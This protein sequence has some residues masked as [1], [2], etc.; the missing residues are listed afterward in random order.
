MHIIVS[1]LTYHYTN[2]QSLFEAIRFSVPPGGKAAIVGS[3]G[4][5][6][7]TLLKLLAGRLAPVSGSIACA[8]HPYYI[9]QQPDLAGTSVAEALGAAGK[10]AALHAIC[11]GSTDP[12]HYDA[13]GDDWEIE[14][15][16]RAALDG[17]GLRHVAPDAPA[18]AL[19]GGEKTK[20]LL[21][22]AT[23]RQPEILLL[24]EPTNHL[25]EAGRRQLYAFV[26]DT[27]ATVVVV[28]HDITLLNLLETIYELS[29]LGLKRYGGNYD[30]Y[31]QQKQIE[32]QAIE[33]HLDAA[34][35]A[36][37]QAR[38]R[39]QEVRERQEKRAAQGE[40]KKDQSPRILRK[41]LKDSGERTASRL[42]DQHAALIGRDSEKIAELRARQQRE[43]LLR[44][45]FD[46]AQLHNGKLLA[47]A[48]GVNFAYPGGAPL[49]SAPL[50]TTIRSG[51]RIRLRGGNGTGK[52][53]LVKLLTGEL[54]PTKGEIRRSEFSRVCLDQEYSRL[55]T[56]ATV[57]ETAQACNRSHLE[58]HELK[59]RLHRAL[60]P[61]AA[62]DKAC[63]TLSGGE[64]MRLSLCCL[65][66]ENQ[67][68]D[69]FILDEPTNNL[70]LQS[71]GILTD[72]IRNYRGTLLLIS[73][74]SRFAEEVGIT[75]TIS[76]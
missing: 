75:R 22:G 19:S 31:R 29:P 21:A 65:I 70:D 76:L 58:E 40:K 28:S 55:D 54:E 68:P 53:T 12:A 59:T 6:K 44:I 62:W 4:T 52:T 38:R 16:C 46:D 47:E 49:W 67:V 10:L 5:G 26:R 27:R 17:W 30:F 64:R 24:D 71:L 66:I 56:P 41:G 23:L 13:L 1:D 42:R 25:D 48:R 37:K 7:S 32:R 33:Q 35:T 14:S 9:P 15:K 73:H 18:D 36:L 74:D 60:F 11:A 63:D 43:C 34:Q 45:D 50:D 61:A 72:T 3:N 51:E 2:R 69:L 8:A 20:L 57:L 39:A